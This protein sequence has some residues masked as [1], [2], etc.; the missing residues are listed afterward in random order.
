MR[1]PEN[2]EVNGTGVSQW[3][4]GQSAEIQVQA[5]LIRDLVRQ[6]LEKER[7]SM[8]DKRIIEELR[9]ALDRKECVEVVKKLVRDNE[10][11]Q[12]GPP[13]EPNPR[14]RAPPRRDGGCFTCGQTDHWHRDCPMNQVSAT[15][16]QL[17]EDEPD[18]SKDCRRLQSDRAT[19][20]DTQ[21]VMSSYLELS[22]EGGPIQCLVDSGA[23]TSVFPASCVDE[24]LV[25]DTENILRAANGT[26]IPV[27]GE[28][29]ISAGSRVRFG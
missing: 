16:H 3:S 29:E 6:A 19:L 11:P 28:A 9:R 8:E 2:Y 24:C 23:E 18:D 10:K 7:Q 14:Q 21:Q 20:P 27:I 13:A 22:T 1:Q 12:A 17:R 26:V 4:N 25:E 5:D 15:Q